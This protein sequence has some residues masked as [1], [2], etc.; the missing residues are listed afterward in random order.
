MSAIEEAKPPLSTEG[1]EN[2][3]IH[4]DRRD[5]LLSEYLLPDDSY[6]NGVY[7]ADLPNGERQAWINQSSNAEARREL[8]NIGRSFKEDPINP[9]SHYFGKYVQNGMGLF[10]E[11]YTLFSIGN[12]SPLFSAVW[13]S[14]WK[15]HKTCNVLWIDA[16]TYLEICGIIIGQ[17]AVGI[18]GDWIGRKFGLVQDAAVMLLGVILLTSVWGTTLNGW[19]I[20]YA[21]SLFIYGVGVGGEYPM[22]STRALETGV[23]GPAGT[24]D[25]RM[26]RGRNVVLAFLMQGWGQVFNQVILILLFVIFHAGKTTAPYNEK[27]AQYTYR[28]SFGIVAILHTWLLYHRIYHIKDADTAVKKAKK[29][30]NT[31][32]YDRQSLNL[33]MGHYW[34]RLIA[35]AIGWFANDF[36]FYGNKI[37]AGVFIGIIKPGASLFVTW[38]FNLI[39]IAVSLCGY[40]MAALLIDHK[41][42]GR[43]TMQ[44]VGFFF[45]FLLFLFGAIFFKEL[46]KP[47]APIAG[48]QAMYYL[49]SFFNQFGPNCTS[50]LVA[51][52]IFPA[53]I[54]ATAHGVSA[55]TGK[56]G[57]LAPTILYN[58]IG[59]QTKFWVVPWFGLLG[60]MV[61]WAFLPDT[62]GLDLREQE[63]YWACVR[64]GRPEDYHGIAVHRRHLSWYEIHVLHRDRHYDA[65][66]DK[67]AKIDELRVLY[68]SWAIAQR[69]ESGDSD[70]VDHAFISPDIVKY[71]ESEKDLP[72][73][74][75]TQQNKEAALQSQGHELHLRSKLEETMRV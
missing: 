3:D 27:F 57:A 18:E 48:L 36:F 10:V 24:R 23:N 75:K 12:L 11:G 15:T 50:F 13:P 25:D 58:Y 7:W 16:V 56:L 40:Y 67:E 60:A 43:K 52:E 73:R 34:H 53:S 26:H 72:K 39:N 64:A 42:Y 74:I 55:A 22:T 38:E 45:D 8:G 63:R 47:G 66:L 21:W 31:S 5:A 1:S 62:T 32:G 2:T 4:A 65:E 68:E 30:L 17:I 37:F 59:N 6:I 14:C 29:R 46:Q 49:S 69:D 9:L 70:D 44:Q 28:V 41:S 35:S 19:V 33:I 61:T 20:G 54:R 71:F 51:A